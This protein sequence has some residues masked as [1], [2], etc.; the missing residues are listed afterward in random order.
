LA[1]PKP[2]PGMTVAKIIQASLG[3]TEQTLDGPLSSGPLFVMT[4]EGRES[5]TAPSM[6]PA[7][8]TYPYSMPPKPKRKS[9]GP[10]LS[11]ILSQLLTP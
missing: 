5:T 8:P 7:N 9:R 10:G 4:P 3:A 2:I 11:E 6:K 1:K